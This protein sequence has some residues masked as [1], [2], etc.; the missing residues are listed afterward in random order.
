MATTVKVK[1]GYQKTLRFTLVKGTLPLQS[2]QAYFEGASG[3][4]YSEEGEEIVLPGVED[5][6]LPP[7]GEWQDRLYTVLIR[8]RPDAKA[9]MPAGIPTQVVMA[10]ERKIPIFEDRDESCGK[11][12]PVDEF[13]TTITFAFERYNVRE[14]QRGQFLLDFLQAGPKV[15]VKSLLSSGKTVTE[16]LTYLRSSYGEPLTSGEL[17]RK[18]LGRRQQRG[19]SVREF[20]VDLEKL[21]HRLNKKDPGLYKQPEVIIRE[22]FVD[23]IAT[24]GLRHSCRDLLDRSPSITF[25]ELKD[26]TIKRAEREQAHFSAVQQEGF[27]SSIAAGE[28]DPVK[29]LEG[30]MRVVMKKLDALS[31]TAS[32]HPGQQNPHVS[33][34][35]YGATS[36]STPAPPR[37]YNCDQPGHFARDCWAPR[38][39]QRG[40]FN[41]YSRPLT[42]TNPFHPP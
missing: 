16:A 10:P 18:F 32:R 12:I 35:P 28:E 19:E 41:R 21:F 33:A 3:L 8:E 15:E 30:Q 9:P 17:Q 11:S 1:D 6:I 20:G 42:N 25:A 40:N 22:Q 37:C 7:A 24:E 29:K 27:V 23:G 14:E 34:F 26:W 39:P 38:R 31:A 36:P 13:V 2:L 5:T 4:S